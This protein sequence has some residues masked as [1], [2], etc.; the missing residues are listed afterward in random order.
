MDNLNSESEGSLGLL[1]LLAAVGIILGVL[2]LIAL[3]VTLVIAP[4]TK[5]G[6]ERGY[7][8]EVSCKRSARLAGY[9]DFKIMGRESSSCEVLVWTGD[10]VTLDYP[11]VTEGINR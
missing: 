5:R 10:L 9:L 7:I 6:A 1:G 11:E 8:E 2:G 4:P 3:L